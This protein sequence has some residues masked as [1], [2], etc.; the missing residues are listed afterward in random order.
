MS[1][2]LRPSTVCVLTVCLDEDE[3]RW[4]E[5]EEKGGGGGGGGDG[6]GGGG[7]EAK[8]FY[9]LFSGSTQRHLTTTLQVN[10]VTLQAVCPAHDA[11]EQVVVTLC[12]VRPDGQVD[13][14]AQQHFLY[15]PDLALSM[16]HFLLSN[17][18]PQGVMLLDD[19][20]ECERLD[21]SLAL[22]LRHLTWPRP[23]PAPGVRPERIGTAAAADETPA[24]EHADIRGTADL[25]KLA[26]A[27]CAETAMDAE[28]L[29]DTTDPAMDPEDHIDVSQWGTHRWAGL[30]HFAASRGLR[31][32][33]LFLLRQPAAREALRQRDARG[34]TPA[35]L[36]RAKGHLQLAA[37][38]TRC[39]ASAEEEEEEDL[40]ENT[41]G[42]LQIYPEG[43]AFQCHPG[44][45]TYTLTL[46]AHREKEK[47]RE[48]GDRRRSE[49][50]LLREEVEELR[51][52]VHIHR[53]LKV[54]VATST[55]EKQEGGSA[56]L[57]LETST[58]EAKTGDLTG[59][60]TNE[61]HLPGETEAKCNPTSGGDT[62]TKV[63]MGQGQG[64]QDSET[65]PRE[66]TGPDSEQAQGPGLAQGDGPKLS[67]SPGKSRRILWRDG[68][69]TGGADMAFDQRPEAVASTVWYQ[70]DESPDA[71]PT[72]RTTLL[73]QRTEVHAQTA[74]M[75]V[76]Q[77]SASPQ[78]ENGHRGVWEQMES[79][80]C[81]AQALGV[82]GGGTRE[83]LETDLC[84]QVS[85]SALSQAGDPGLQ[86]APSHVPGAQRQEASGKQRDEGRRGEEAEERK[87]RG[88]AG[89]A[90]VEVGG[91]AND[92]RRRRADSTE[93][94]EQGPE[95]G[96]EQTATDKGRKKRRRKKAR[97]GA[98][99]AKLSSS[100]STESHVPMDAE[101][102]VRAEAD[103]QPQSDSPTAETPVQAELPGDTP[104]EDKVSGAKGSE[105]RGAMRK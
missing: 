9:L 101:A 74:D 47:E 85:V 21:Q 24:A 45:G 16:A 30:L 37:I 62:E 67:P 86:P 20:Q 60:Q 84:F 49:S 19:Q 1:L 56:E 102:E 55:A 79:A 50:R 68:G 83:P 76:N 75:A 105:T 4:P 100:S 77:T 72:E 94:L 12:A 51:R 14:Q 44:L 41:E 93:S 65:V 8:V 71:P 63:S 31:R 96:A 89:G 95:E 69:W 36:A 80:L 82:G 28:I 27:A 81:H 2:T 103:A 48:G 34:E 35:S 6:D 33:V 25:D 10:H 90:C 70:D 22:A 40:Q 104:G 97:R 38:L 61:N 17:G 5:Q 39:E 29:V 58:S 46:P 59:R 92:D 91:D 18:A 66:P 53:E 73:S 13:P 64:S 3:A 11:C 88:A 99:E 98:V 15:V 52:L 32:V 26:V 78:S 23:R 54:V 43:R 42:H 87:E 57:G 7:G